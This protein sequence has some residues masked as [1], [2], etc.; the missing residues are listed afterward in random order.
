L[1]ALPINCLI[2]RSL[3][4]GPKQQTELRRAAGSPA[5]TTLRAQLKKLCAIGAVERQRRNSFP[6]SIEHEL[7][8]AGLDL[9]T[10][11]DAVERWL[12]S[13]PDGPVEF[14][15]SEA[16]AAIKAL[17]EGWSTAML[18]VLAAKPL[19]LTELDGVIV[20]L[21]YPSLERR[22]TA[23]KLAG[24]VEQ[25]PGNGRG[26]RYRVSEWTC[27][28]VAPLTAAAR[29]ERRHLSEATPPVGKLDAEGIFLL[30]LPLL[31]LPSELSG[32]CRL[33]VGIKNGGG[34]RLVGVLVA[35]ED[36]NVVSFSTRLDGRPQA[37]ASG[38]S[39]T[40]LNALVERDTDKLEVGGDGRLARSLLDSLHEF[41]TGTRTVP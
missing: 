12:E 7:T 33:A 6:G 39:S 35:I 20:S 4:E 22:L 1:L 36:G 2:L 24:Q 13:A 25:A 27:R 5:Q 30:A 29:W 23:M 32:T 14:G 34:E 31:R 3:G 37:W 26:T 18:R 38:S 8:G 19:T 21:N 28:A 9:L 40:W 11:A 16:K 15:S 10:V 17:V 41:M